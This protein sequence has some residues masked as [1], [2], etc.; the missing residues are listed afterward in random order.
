MAALTGL[1]HL[2]IT[3]IRAGKQGTA[4]PDTIARILACPIQPADGTATTSWWTRKYINALRAEGYDD[5][6]IRAWI[7][8]APADV[9]QRP[10]V[11]QRTARRTA[12]IYRAITSD[13]L[14]F[15]TGRATFVTN[16]ARLESHA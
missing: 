9:F 2:V 13:A 11:R 5:A 7:G 1:S 4:R 15:A 16:S 10:R 12:T 14:A 8:L 6:N 3:R